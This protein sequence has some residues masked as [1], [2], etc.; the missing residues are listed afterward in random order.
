MSLPKRPFTTSSLTSTL[1]STIA[2]QPLLGNLTNIDKLSSQASSLA[3]KTPFFSAINQ[4]QHNDHSQQHQHPNKSTLGQ[5]N[6][7]PT[8]GLN[9]NN[10]PMNNTING[11]NIF[12][13][14]NRQATSVGSSN[15]MASNS[16]INARAGAPMATPDVDMSHL[17]EEERLM[18]QSVMAK[19]EMAEMGMPVD[20]SGASSTN[21]PSSTSLALAQQTEMAKQQQRQMQQ[22]QQQQSY[23]PQQ[24]QQTQYQVNQNS[25]RSAVSSIQQQQHYLQSD[26]IKTN[27]IGTEQQQHYGQVPTSSSNVYVGQNMTGYPTTTTTTNQ[28]QNYQINQASQQRPQGQ[29]YQ[30]QQQAAQQQQSYNQSMMQQQQQQQQVPS[31]TTTNLTGPSQSFNQTQS[32]MATDLSGQRNELSSL[33]QQTQQLVSQINN[34]FN[35]STSGSPHQHN[36][37]GPNQSSSQMQTNI[38]YISQQ[39]QQVPS[40]QTSFNNSNNQTT[41]SS[42]NRIP[43]NQANV[44]QQASNQM[45]VNQIQQ[46]QPQQQNNYQSSNRAQDFNSMSYNQGQFDMMSLQQQQQQQP[47]QMSFIQAGLSTSQQMMDPSIQAGMTR[48]QM[49]DMTQQ[50]QQQQISMQNNSPMTNNPQSLIYSPIQSQSQSVPLDHSITTQQG[51]RFG[52]S[53][54]MTARYND[55]NNEH[56]YSDHENSSHRNHSSTR[57]GFKRHETID[58]N[59]CSRSNRQKNSS[60]RDGREREL[61][62]YD[63]AYSSGMNNNNNNN[64]FHQKKIPRQLPKP[65][66]PDRSLQSSMEQLPS[67]RPNSRQTK[68]TRARGSH[69][70]RR[71]SPPESSQPLSLTDEEFEEDPHEDSRAQS[72]RERER[73]RVQKKGNESS[74]G[75]TNEKVDDAVKVLTSLNLSEHATQVMEQQQLLIKQSQELIRLQLE[76]Q[77]LSQELKKSL[78]ESKNNN[79]TNLGDAQT[80]INN[81][82]SQ[83]NQNEKLK[84]TDSISQMNDNEMMN[85]SIEDTKNKSADKAT[86]SDDKERLF[87]NNNS[88]SNSNLIETK[89]KQTSMR[90]HDSDNDNMSRN[91]SRSTRYNNDLNLDIGNQNTDK[92]EVNYFD[93]SKKAQSITISRG[94]RYERDILQSPTDTTDSD[95]EPLSQASARRQNQRSNNNNNNNH[96]H[97]QINARAKSITRRREP[98]GLPP[99]PLPVAAAIQLHQMQQQHYR[100]TG[101]ANSNSNRTSRARTNFLRSRSVTSSPNHHLDNSNSGYCT[102]N[103]RNRSTSPDTLSEF[104]GQRR[105]KRLPEPPSNAVPVTPSM[106]RKIV[107]AQRSGASIGKLPTSVEAQSTFLTNTHSNKSLLFEKP[108]IDKQ[109]GI[110]SSELS[111]HQPIISSTSTL[112][113]TTT[114]TTSSSYNPSFTISSSTTQSDPINPKSS[115]S[116]TGDL[117]RFLS[118]TY[119][120]SILRNTMSDIKETSELDKLISNFDSLYGIGGA[121]RQV[122]LST[123]SDILASNDIMS[124]INTKPISS[125]LPPSISPK[126]QI[127]TSPYISR[128]GYR[129][130]QLS[131]CISEGETT[132]PNRL[133]RRYNQGPT[134]IDS[135]L[136]SSPLSGSHHLDNPISRT[137]PPPRLTYSG[138]PNTQSTFENRSYLHGQNFTPS[139][140][141]NPLSRQSSL[142]NKLIGHDEFNQDLV[143]SNHG[144]YTSPTNIPGLTSSRYHIGASSSSPFD[145][146]DYRRDPLGITNTSRYEHYDLSEPTQRPINTMN[147]TR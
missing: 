87:N 24:Q 70:T 73:D 71:D 80:D 38:G 3:Q 14:N 140:Q 110:R 129:N 104:G 18:I 130:P 88:N 120:N 44:T 13:G 147:P 102:D 128:L 139:I 63:L 41:T 100:Q 141:R 9:Y 122:R 89:K 28:Q 54:N 96:N 112:I 35:L 109:T 59:D 134:M 103:Q 55:F 12:G 107:Q 86:G 101:G 40:L 126:R 20:T 97:N 144:R 125:Y 84:R 76:Q 78:Q 75:L 93:S 72:S 132:L 33:G 77:A 4:Q 142:S 121:K 34:E 115:F 51:I 60:S 11:T 90:E 69:S 82:N 15:T 45:I 7:S 92:S 23:Q 57:P 116:K 1:K 43:S 131:R 67:D 16:P 145:S 21:L 26:Q 6:S 47:T 79:S 36:T 94:S 98:T 111:R 91:A 8:T 5:A 22:Q 137:I 123:E 99:S 48:S 10:S 19:A 66:Q 108:L 136:N 64:Q 118:S 146:L 106:V 119:G 52:A 17:T 83:D 37:L 30:Q 124:S 65:N 50:Q 56:A 31:T 32:H 62:A 143:L 49:L 85:N 61:Q 117:N 39:Q 25:N 127:T 114:S 138:I 46:Q 133:D 58:M 27:Q 2:N 68:R 135:T 53:N 74:K 42:S 113:T 29:G 105:R 95:I 81:N